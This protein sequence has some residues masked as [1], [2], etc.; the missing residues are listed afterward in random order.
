MRQRERDLRRQCA[1]IAER[2][3]ARFAGL[4]TTGSGH[5]KATF[6]KNGATIS[7]TFAATPGDW[8]ATHHEAARARRFLR[9][10]R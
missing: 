5:F 9:G 8:R 2:E 6:N 3:G 1:A 4:Y 10:Q 7:H